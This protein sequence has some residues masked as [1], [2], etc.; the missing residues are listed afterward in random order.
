[1]Y[2]LLHQAADFLS[3]KWG[4]ECLAPHSMTAAMT[5]VQLPEGGVLPAAGT[6]TSA[7]AKYVQ[8]CIPR[9]MTLNQ[10]QSVGV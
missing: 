3:G 9:V 8:V 6:A 5:L 2:W 4:T 10:T 1:M 7:D